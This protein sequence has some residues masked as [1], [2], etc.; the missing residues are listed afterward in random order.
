MN[1]D[2]YCN[3]IC[4]LH[5]RNAVRNGQTQQ[6]DVVC[7]FHHNHHCNS[8]DDDNSGDV[9]DRLNRNGEGYFDPTA[10]EAMKNILKGAKNTMDIYRG[11]IF[12]VEGRTN[13]YD[14]G[15]PCVIVSNNTGNHFSNSVEV[16]WLTTAEKKTLPTHVEII[17]GQKATAMCEGIATIHKDRLTNYMRTCTQRE[18]QAI[19]KA[20]KVSLGLDEGKGN[21][22]ENRAEIE[23]L[24]RHNKLLQTMIE[25]SDAF[26]E[27]E[28]SEIAHLK[29]QIRQME[30]SVVLTYDDTIAKLKQDVLKAQIE[31]DTYKDLYE[32]MLHKMIG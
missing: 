11:D 10:F 27:K 25:D 29:E 24:K 9:M 22:D 6:A 13:G 1:E 3:F 21:T 2:I 17:A 28:E 23:D 30:T 5:W 20:L 26:H 16:V 15:R 14:K 8:A 12:F 18:M 19:D 7:L 32:S 4:V 31:R